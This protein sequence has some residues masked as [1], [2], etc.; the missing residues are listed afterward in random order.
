MKKIG[1][2]MLVI[3]LLS[4]LLTGCGDSDYQ[5]PDVVISRLGKKIYTAYVDKDAEAIKEMLSPNMQNREK[6]DKEID[7]FLNI[8]DGNIVG[9]K[10]SRGSAGAGKIRDGEYTVQIGS[11]SV[12]KITTDTGKTYLRQWFYVLFLIFL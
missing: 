10:E 12:H 8:I 9:Y 2:I 7:A 4:T 6:T 5:N 1:L 3:L 11:G